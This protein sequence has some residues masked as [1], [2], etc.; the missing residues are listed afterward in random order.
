MHCD[1]LKKDEIAQAIASPVDKPNLCKICGQNQS[2]TPNNNNT[3]QTNSILGNRNI[4]AITH[5]YS[6]VKDKPIHN[7][8]N[9]TIAIL[10]EGIDQ[11]GNEDNVN[12]TNNTVN[13]VVPIVQQSNACTSANVN[14][15]REVITID[16]NTLTPQQMG[17]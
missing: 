5:P 10:D 4:L 16:Q 3:L 17:Q 11:R 9:A 7:S 8:N 1:K 13:K 14:N 2:R 12:D 6:S 15:S